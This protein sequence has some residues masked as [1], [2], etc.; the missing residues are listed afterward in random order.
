MGKE[1]VQIVEDSNG[2]K[3]VKIEE[4]IFR[5]KQNIDWNAVEIYLKKY[6]DKLIKVAETG[7]IIHIKRDFVDEY[8]NGR[9]TRKILKGGNAKAKANAS[10]GI[11]QMIQI[12]D[13][14][15]YQENRKEKHRKDA[16]NGWYYYKTRFAIPIMNEKLNEISYCIYSAELI[17]QHSADGK[18]YLYDIKNIK[19]ETE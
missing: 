19:K 18:L 3:Y 15:R 16:K 17:V 4:I 11:L 9:Y 12:A 7:D 13:N 14:K 10:Q 8:A 6:I 2:R 1:T 5:G